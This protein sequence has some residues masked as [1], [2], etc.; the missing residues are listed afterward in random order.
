MQPDGKSARPIVQLKR[1]QLEDSPVPAP[2]S[3]GYVN[4]PETL[5]VIPTPPEDV[6]AVFELPTD[7]SISDAGRALE[8]QLGDALQSTGVFPNIS[9]SLFCAVV[10]FLLGEGGYGRFLC[11]ANSTAE[12]R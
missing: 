11:L 10:L 5:K 3:T 9:S 4:V 6:L 1:T 8:A 12:Q 7:T 2:K